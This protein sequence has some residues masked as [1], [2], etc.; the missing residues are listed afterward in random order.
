EIIGE[1]RLD[2]AIKLRVPQVLPPF[3]ELSRLGCDAVGGSRAH[4]CTPRR[5]HIH[6]RRPVS[7]FTPSR[8]LFLRIGRAAFR[9]GQ[10][11]NLPRFARAVRLRIGDRIIRR[12]QGRK[13]QAQ[14]KQLAKLIHRSPPFA[15]AEA[16]VACVEMKTSICWPTKNGTGE[17][18]N[19]YITCNTRV[20]TRSV[21]SPV[22]DFFGTT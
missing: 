21:L 13:D 12:T 14:T 20:S 6:A 15:E 7:S 18:P 11:G 19:R 22:S 10:V 1:G 4:C 2:E 5:G 17:S 3:F 9:G 16:S 8:R